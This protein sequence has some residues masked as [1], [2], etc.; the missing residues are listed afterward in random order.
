MIKTT[1]DTYI[2]SNTNVRVSHDGI[3]GETTKAVCLLYQIEVDGIMMNRTTY[4]PKSVISRIGDNFIEI[5]FWLASQKEIM[6]PRIESVVG[7]KADT[8]K[9]PETKIAKK[10][11]VSPISYKRKIHFEGEI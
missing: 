8:L 7:K 3:I 4:V 5:P 11:E 6:Q 9:L 2:P 1:E 10:P